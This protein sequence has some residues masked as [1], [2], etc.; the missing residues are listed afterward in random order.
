M[1]QWEKLCVTTQICFGKTNRMFFAFLSCTYLKTSNTLAGPLSHNFR[2]SGLRIICLDKSE[3]HVRREPPSKKLIA[4]RPRL[5]RVLL[6]DR[7]VFVCFAK[8]RHVWVCAM[9]TTIKENE[10][11]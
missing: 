8:W 4:Q 6:D 10:E 11:C 1:T 9:F 2:A 7:K 5:T 3:V